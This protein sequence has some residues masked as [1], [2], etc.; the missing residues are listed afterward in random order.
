MFDDFF[1]VLFQL[2]L[3]LN[4]ECPELRLCLGAD[5]EGDYGKWGACR[6]GLRDIGMETQRRCYMIKL[7]QYYTR[8]RSTFGLKVHTAINTT[9]GGSQYS[10]FDALSL[11]GYVLD[12]EVLLDRDNEPIPIPKLWRRRS[13]QTLAASI[14]EPTPRWKGVKSKLPQDLL[15][16]MRRTEEGKC[17]MDTGSEVK[18]TFPVPQHGH[19]VGLTSLAS[20]WGSKFS[21]VP[22]SVSRKLVIEANG[23]SHYAQNCDHTLGPTILK[24]RHLEYLGWEVLNVSYLW[25]GGTLTVA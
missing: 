13:S 4:K 9:L 2:K 22:A 15:E 20:D 12:F 17:D 18:H 7:K 19:N 23:T 14:G 1:A 25:E 10:Q 21:K 6:S 8:G 11:G 16:D 5:S 3:S 24:T